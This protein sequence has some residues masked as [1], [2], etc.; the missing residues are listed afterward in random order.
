MPANAATHFLPPLKKTHVVLMR[1][2]IY[3]WL[4]NEVLPKHLSEDKITH[5]HTHTHSITRDP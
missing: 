2:H 4:M 1:L 5:T 3:T